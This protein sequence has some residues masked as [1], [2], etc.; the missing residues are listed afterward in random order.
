M[1]MCVVNG[2]VH[3]SCWYVLKPTELFTAPNQWA[4]ISVARAL[5][6][7][8]EGKGGWAERAARKT[9]QWLRAAH[10]FAKPEKRWN[11]RFAHEGGGPE[12]ITVC[13]ESTQ[14]RRVSYS[15]S[16]RI[17][18]TRGEAIHGAIAYSKCRKEGWKKGEEGKEEVATEDMRAGVLFQRMD[19]IRIS[20]CFFQ[21]VLGGFLKGFKAA[22]VGVRFY[23]G[24]QI[25]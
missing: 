19:E 17:P 15:T 12:N 24:T 18:P 23:Y 25:S 7:G 13:R 2:G 4:E 14:R 11:S 10:G 3:H 16:D 9:G 8:E 6:Q 22:Y 21:S 20:F 1:K 5:R